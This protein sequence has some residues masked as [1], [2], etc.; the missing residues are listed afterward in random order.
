MKMAMAKRKPI[1]YEVMQMIEHCAFALRHL[2]QGK[3]V[4]GD[5]EHLKKMAWRYLF[6]EDG[7]DTK[8][9]EQVHRFSVYIDN[10]NESAAELAL[11]TIIIGLANIETQQK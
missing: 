6:V 4:K 11:T 5:A 3:F 7:H 1:A 2:Q 8:I 9:P 10:G